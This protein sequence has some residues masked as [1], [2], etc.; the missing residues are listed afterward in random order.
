MSFPFLVPKKVRIDSRKSWNLWKSDEQHG[1]KYGCSIRAENL[2]CPQ[3]LLFVWSATSYH[4]TRNVVQTCSDTTSG[5]I[6]AIGRLCITES[7]IIAFRRCFAAAETRKSGRHGQKKHALKFLEA[8]QFLC[9]LLPEILSDL[10]SNNS[11]YRMRDQ[12]LRL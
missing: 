2:E 3:N 7:T 8:I 4:T 9:Y 12:W 6:A 5:T 10:V 11:L 1:Y